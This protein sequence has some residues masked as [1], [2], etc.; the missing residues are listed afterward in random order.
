MQNSDVPTADYSQLTLIWTVGDRT[1]RNVYSYTVKPEDVGKYVHLK[2]KGTGDYY[3][4]IAAETDIVSESDSGIDVLQWVNIVPNKYGKIIA[5]NKAMGDNGDGTHYLYKKGGT[6]VTCRFCAKRDTERQ[7]WNTPFQDALTGEC[8]FFKWF[9]VSAY[10]VKT[11]NLKSDMYQ[12]RQYIKYSVYDN[13]ENAKNKNYYDGSTYIP[14]EDYAGYYLGVEIS[15][16]HTDTLS[17]KR[18]NTNFGGMVYDIYTKEPITYEKD[19]YTLYW[20]IQPARPKNANGGNNGGNAWNST[21][22]NSDN[23]A[24]VEIPAERQIGVGLYNGEDGTAET[25]Q[26]VVTDLSNNAV[27][28]Q[29]GTFTPPA[30]DVGKTYKIVA[31]LADGSTKETT[32]EVVESSEQ[33][34]TKY[35]VTIPS[36][37]TVKNAVV[38]TVIPSSA[39]ENITGIKWY[40]GSTE[41]EGATGDSYTPKEEDENSELKAV[42]TFQ[43]SGSDPE[44]VESNVCKIKEEDDD[45]TEDSGEKAG[46]PIP[47]IKTAHLRGGNW[48]TFEKDGECVHDGDDCYISKVDWDGVGFIAETQANSDEKAENS[49]FHYMQ[50]R[51]LRASVANDTCTV[52]GSETYFDN[53]TSLHREYTSE[54]TGDYPTTSSGSN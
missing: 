5:G 46:D 28:S 32:A 49:L 10:R 38:I 41:I 36:K 35:N 31:Q 22:I 33:N 40:K 19:Y 51:S 48:I 7:Y 11:C 50:F 43:E 2:I 23:P 27:I 34:G 20:R 37:G 21:L 9:V 54:T 39:K 25:A 4:F 52:Y 18:N 29:S 45:E 26:I 8:L 16:N 24:V 3:G 47:P 17:H 42:V 15:G 14:L 44:T 12:H 53:D 6:T 30:I 1:I 13:I